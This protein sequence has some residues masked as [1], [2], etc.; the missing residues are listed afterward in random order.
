MS[1]FASRRPRALRALL[2]ASA[3][4]AG[5]LSAGVA[6][7]L[8]TGGVVVGQ[9][10][11]SGAT[12]TSGPSTTTISQPT[13]QRVVIDWSTFNI[14]NGETVTFNQGAANFIAFNRINANAGLT[15]INGALNAKD[16]KSTRLNSSHA[17][18]SY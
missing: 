12:I 2:L 13:S 11:G 16:R 6:Q 7:A 15:T 4:G 18:I 14:A 17:N 8:P 3:A 9:T 1:V 10:T 5:L